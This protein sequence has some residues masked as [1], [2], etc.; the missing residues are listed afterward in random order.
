[1]P[2]FN[3]LHKLD[4]TPELRIN[5][6]NLAAIGQFQHLRMLSIRIAA[7]DCTHLQGSLQSL[8]ALRLGGRPL[9]LQSF[10]AATAPPHLQD[11]SLFFLHDPSPERLSQC[12][13]TI[14]ATVPSTLSSLHLESSLVFAPA[15]TSAMDVVQPALALRALTSF[16]LK[17]HPLPSV[18]D[19]DLTAMLAAW[20]RLA[21]LRIPNGRHPAAEPR[22]PAPPR[23]RPTAGVLPAL[24][25]RGPLLRELVLPEVDLGATPPLDALP[26]VTA[27]VGHGLRV[28]DL[29]SRCGDRHACM[30][31]AVMLDRLFPNM[32]LP[33]VRGDVYG[34]KEEKGWGAV[35]RLLDAMQAGR[36]HAEAF[37]RVWGERGDGHEGGRES[38]SGSGSED[39]DEAEDE[40]EDGDEGEDE[41]VGEDGDGDED[42]DIDMG[43][44]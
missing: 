1:M 6:S 11:L 36:K 8:T 32:V 7:A 16:T 12:L 24:A 18:S 5:A 10:L 34:E 42:K 28:L 4:I 35:V 9:H 30:R 39:E 2:R 43:V 14:L 25:A 20:P 19:A 23:T 41:D 17:F 27:T 29:V 13:P 38:S 44:E 15:L 31:A 33:A 40:D 21:A 3:A 26:P 37:E 22:H